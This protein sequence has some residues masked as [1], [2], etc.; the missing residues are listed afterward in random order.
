MF[1]GIV[2]TVGILRQI[3]HSE[4]GA[5]AHVDTGSID[6]DDAEIGD[7]LAVSGICLTV[8]EIEA[9][10]VK[11]FVSNETL[12]CTVF[13]SYRE[14]TRL[15][16]E[17]PLRMNQGLGGHFVSGHVDGIGRCVQSARDGASL[18]LEVKVPQR[19]GRFIATKG[20][21]ALDGV[22]LTINSAIDG[23]ESTIFSVNIIPHT[24]KAT[25]LGCLSVGDR[26]NIEV[27]VI[28]RYVDRLAHF[29]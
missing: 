1:S 16:L 24:L 9:D 20:S 29:R 4:N 2:E 5:E 14:G 6:L 3:S 25:T 10:A 26:L 11:V 23:A 22:S 17:R 18:R 7:S 19:L 15:N 8:T 21:I 28:A 27:D 13:G 12:S